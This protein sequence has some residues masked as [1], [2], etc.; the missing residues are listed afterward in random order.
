LT[1]RDRDEAE[2]AMSEAEIGRSAPVNGDRRQRRA[3]TLLLVT[4][5][6][7]L[8]QWLP[9]LLVAVWVSWLILH[10]RLEGDLGEALVRLWRRT[11][12]PHTVVL[13][14]LLTANAL[15]YWVYAPVPGG[16]MPFT[17][18]L[19]GLSLLLFGDWW[20]LLAHSGR[21]RSAPVA[22]GRVS[23]PVSGKA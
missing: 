7:W 1:V 3:A 15:A 18:N 4:S 12:P 5:V 23:D 6:L 9:A 16:V 19:L 11:W 20:A 10:K 13:V 21:L 17:L 8:H 14:P 22:P 2:I